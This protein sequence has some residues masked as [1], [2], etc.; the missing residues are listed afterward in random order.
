MSEL[1]K[2][3]NLREVEIVDFSGIKIKNLTTLDKQSATGMA[4]TKGVQV[5]NVPE[6]TG[7]AGFLQPKDVVLLFNR[8]KINNTR[9][10]LEA[11]MLVIGS[12]C[13]MIVFR[14]QKEVKIWVD[15]K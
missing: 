8:K 5:L 7:L 14:T 13:E 10:L 9:D 11:R 6:N 12:S 2:L 1:L 3:S 15:F 4:D